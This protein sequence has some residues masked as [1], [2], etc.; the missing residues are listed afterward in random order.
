MLLVLMKNISSS[1]ILSRYGNLEKTRACMP[2]IPLG[3]G[4]GQYDQE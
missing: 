4:A 3:N 2:L 1:A